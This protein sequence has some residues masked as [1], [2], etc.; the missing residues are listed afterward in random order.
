MEHHEQNP[1][2]RIF[3][4]L[5]YMRTNGA[6]GEASLPIVA[7]Y[8][9]AHPWT[10]AMYEAQARMVAQPPLMKELIEALVDPVVPPG[11]LLDE[12]D[13]IVT[14]IDG[15]GNPNQPLAGF[16][17]GYDAGTL[18]SLAITSRLL[19]SA[20]GARPAT[21]SA[22]RNIR[23]ATETLLSQVVAD[24]GLPGDVKR[25]LVEHAHAILRAL[26]LVKVGGVEVV[27]EE[28]DRMY[29]HLRRDP[30]LAAKVVRRQKIYQVVIA[31]GNVMGALAAMINGGVA[32]GTGFESLLAIDSPPVTVGAPGS[33][34]TPGSTA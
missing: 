6:D 34:D 7:S 21:E 18:K 4:F 14:T 30:A 33:G 10:R 25:I 13:R 24:G 22:L 3:L 31:V 5:T 28:Y 12:Y 29:G 1:A 32:L 20:E 19:N 23:R 17:A 16:R 15:I 9:N 11:E 8:F 26:D 27:L 2:G